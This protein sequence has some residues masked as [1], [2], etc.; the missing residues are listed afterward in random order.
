V[1]QVYSWGH[2]MTTFLKP[3]GFSQFGL[4]LTPLIPI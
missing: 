1:I 4:G 2:F 3:L